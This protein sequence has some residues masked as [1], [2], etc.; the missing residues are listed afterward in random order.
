MTQALCPLSIQLP[1]LLGPSDNIEQQ[2]VSMNDTYRHS[3]WHGME[4]QVLTKYS[5]HLPRGFMFIQLLLTRGSWTEF[6]SE[7]EK[8]ERRAQYRCI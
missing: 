1:G 5:R 7:S 3:S 6:A 2:T 8:R 4:R